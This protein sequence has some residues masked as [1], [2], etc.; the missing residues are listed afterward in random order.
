M[1]FKHITLALIASLGLTAAQAQEQKTEAVF[2]PHW[3]LQLQGGAQYTL[4]EADFGD[5]ISPNIQV[6]VGRQ[7]S[8]VWGARLS[9]NAW[10]SKAAIET[11]S[12][13]GPDGYAVAFDNEYAWK[14]KYVAPMLDATLNLSNLICGYC[15]TRVVSVSLLAGI[16]AN[17]A[18]DNDGA[19]EA[20]KL[21]DANHTVPS[22]NV[23][24]LWDGTATRI[25]GRFGAAVDF[26]LSD[27]VS[28]GLE[29]QANTLN[30]HYNSKR[31]GNADWYFNA[32]AGVKVNLGKTHTTRPVEAPAPEIRY[33]DRV[34]E[35]EVPAKADKDC[36]KKQCCKKEDKF[37]RDI[38]FPISNTRVSV[39]EDIKVREVAEY[40]KAHPQAKVSVTGYADKNTGTTAI[41]ARLARQRAAAVAN[42][43]VN[44]YGISRSRITTDSKG[45]TVAPYDTPEKCR[46]SV[47]IAE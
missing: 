17:I 46:V 19:K 16:G 26:R 23:D 12:K 22:Q 44:K 37:R 34:V 10:Q 40:L 43:L 11:M 25:T 14:Y 6:A 38:F 1:N 32:L 24:Y 47:C 28:L 42:Q 31:A 7:F 3:Y 15:P 4:G 39:T 2:A 8:P 36:C 21:A 5:L 35:K 30:D 45:D 33:V 20:F 18:F 9:I 27:A 13:L 29:L 41:N